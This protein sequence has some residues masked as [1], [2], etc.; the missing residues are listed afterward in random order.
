ML[1][2]EMIHR[3]AARS[4][5]WDLVIIGGGA[6][7]AGCAVDAASRGLEVLLLEK[8]DFGKGTS[9]RST[10][11]IHGGVRY[12][13]QADVSLVREALRERGL[14]RNN[15]PKQF[16][17]QTFVV[18]CYSR[19]QKIYY[20]IGLK[21]YD[22]LS[23]RH[24]LGNSRILSRK[25]TID[26][27]PNI[28]QKKL[29]G[30]VLYLDGQFDDARL[31]LDL[32][33]SAATHG[34]C[35]INY[36]DVSGLDKDADGKISGVRFKCRESGKKFSAR[37]RVVINATGAFCDNIRKLSSET[38]KEIVSPSQGIH[39]VF[40]DS[41]LG[42]QTAIM[43][44]KT[45]DGRVLFAIPWKGKTLVGTTDTSIDDVEF[46]PVPLDA[47]IE[48]ILETCREYLAKPPSDSDVLSVFAG[49]R[50]L[51]KAST[52]QNTATLS[53]DH[54]IEIDRQNLVT[55]TGGK[56]TTF[57]HMAED[58]VNQAVQTGGLN[59]KECK[60][61]DQDIPDD[62]AE[63]IRKIIDSDPA[64]SE[65][66]HQ[67]FEYKVADVL[68]AVRY[69]MART[70]EDVLARRTRLLFLDATAANKVAPRVAKIIAGELKRDQAW[71][72]EQVGEFGS[73]T[74][75]YTLGA[76]K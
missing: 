72:E 28:N 7:G 48:F 24:R 1:R 63:V 13:E 73:L 66:L 39:L 40:D 27:L 54:T 70:V 34:A 67:D 58:A 29:V 47:E 23:G 2:D 8:N 10:K 4:T 6:T 33:K 14:L 12:L 60:T 36:A 52:K 11:L 53:R 50:P 64:A 20:G 75:K 25:M 30:G 71:I 37:S 69:D 68:K 62:H 35:V 22:L 42:N 18:P 21:L 43:I 3:A 56:W 46:E 32:I 26:L 55:I 31:L 15:A 44:P 74:Q 59:A 41:F 61:R 57:R 76:Y 9:S 16:R 51:V 45:S 38:A 17:I 65:I 49:I 19:W 5:P